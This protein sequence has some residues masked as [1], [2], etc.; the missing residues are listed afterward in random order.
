M[1]ISILTLFPEM[2]EGPFSHSIIK[3]AAEKDLVTIRI[4]NIRDFG[5]G[6]HKMVDDTPYG[7]GRGMVMRVDVLYEAIEKTKVRTYT[8]DEEKVILLD[9]RG[10]PF[11]QKKAR[12]FAKLAHLIIV[13]G[14][15]EGFDERIRQFVDE[16][17][18]IG[19]FIL[20]G[21]EIPAMAITDAVTRLI[22][23][24]LS[25]EA[26]EYE[27]FSPIEATNEDSMHLEYPQYTKPREFKRLS[28]PDVLLS[29]NH[30]NIASWREEKSRQI[31]VRNRPDL[32]KAG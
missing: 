5:I 18:S 32:V 23:G 4:I 19:D 2:F 27:S 25:P 16:E 14:H 12:S 22:P 30:K 31:T 13:C 15:Y 17:V 29:G 10:I 7:G 9:A 3:H 11:A 20:T 8:R 21:G 28:V 26:T 1:K 6:K 24:V